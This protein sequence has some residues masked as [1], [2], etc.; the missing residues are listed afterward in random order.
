M[1]ERSQHLRLTFESCHAIRVVREGHRQDFDR[2]IA[3]KL[4][5]PGAV[6]L[7]HAARADRRKDFVGSQ[8]SSGGQSHKA[9]NDFILPGVCCTADSE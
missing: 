8:T 5:I 3:S 2:Y 4:D 9:L 6:D 7:P 1:V